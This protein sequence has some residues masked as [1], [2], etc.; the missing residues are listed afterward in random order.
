MPAERRRAFQLWDDW[1]DERARG[2][3]QTRG[4]E[5]GVGRSGDDDLD[6]LD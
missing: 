1:A 5:L 6:V 3:V 2:V 4:R